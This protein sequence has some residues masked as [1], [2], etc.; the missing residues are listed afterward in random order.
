MHVEKLAKFDKMAP[1]TKLPK[2]V[3]TMSKDGPF[4]PW[5][6]ARPWMG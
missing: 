4:G 6:A 1:R 2:W 5:M 3:H